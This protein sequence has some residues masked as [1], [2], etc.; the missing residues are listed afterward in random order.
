[1]TFS[2]NVKGSVARKKL[3]QGLGEKALSNVNGVLDY[4]QFKD[5]DMVIEV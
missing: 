3:P 1:M 4:S 5:I 2:A